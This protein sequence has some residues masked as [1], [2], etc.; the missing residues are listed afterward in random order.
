MKTIKVIIYTNLFSKKFVSKKIWYW[1]T[2][3]IK[4]LSLLSTYRLRKFSNPLSLSKSKCVCFL[5]PGRFS[6]IGPM[7][8]RP[9][10]RKVTQFLGI[11]S[12]VFQ[13][14]CMKLGVHKCR[15]VT[16]PDFS[17]KLSFSKKLG[18]RVQKGLKIGFLDFCAKLDH[19]F[20]LE[21]T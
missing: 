11:G 20:L 7:N 8:L 21:M 12:L 1:D 5:D 16:E 3:K 6:R 4:K 9:S 14:F 2:L 17:G 19:Q 13:I 18:K 10:V 15:K